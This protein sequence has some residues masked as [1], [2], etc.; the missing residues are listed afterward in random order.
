MSSPFSATFGISPKNY[1]KREIEFNKIIEDFENESPYSLVYLLMG[2]RGSGKTV[3]MTSISSYFKE[4]K[5]YVVVDASI[6]DNMIENLASLLYDKAKNKFSSLNYELSFSFNG[7][8]ISLKG[9]KEVSSPMSLLI[10]TL[11]VLKK[12]N[13]KVLITLDEVDNSKEMKTFIESYSSL[14][15]EGYNIRLLM[16]G[17]AKNVYELENN[18][19]LT[20]LIRA[21][22]INLSS[23]PIQ[24]I[25]FNYQ[26]ELNIDREMAFE[27][28]KLTKGYAYAYQLLG[29][30]FFNK[31]NKEIDDE[32]LFEYD[33]SLALY[34][35]NKIYSELSNIDKEII[36]KIETNKEI[37]IKDIQDKLNFNN[38]K[39][40]VYRE[41]LINAGLI[42]SPTY[43]YIEFVLPRFKE[44]LELKDID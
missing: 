23:L 27:L 20:F 15:R 4:K 41:R 28:A 10:N 26:K 22:K 18:S 14:I 1:I 12:K 42:Y 39:F 6:K 13:K 43:G 24:D 40:S 25:I 2:V 32:L 3:L 31:K 9:K 34:S 16:T 37:K 8:S 35:Y 11:E 17:L 29:Y 33:K 19:S 44:F 38:S 30:L 7:V 36:K 5:D 21:P